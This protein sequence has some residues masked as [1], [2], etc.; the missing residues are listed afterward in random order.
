MVVG[1]PLPVPPGAS[2][3]CRRQCRAV[4]CGGEG[5][6]GWGA[7]CGVSPVR[8]GAGGHPSALGGEA[9]EPRGP[10]V[11]PQLPVRGGAQGPWPPG[12]VG[13]CRGE[14]HYVDPHNGGDLLCSQEGVYP[15]P[16][17]GRREGG[18]GDGCCPIEVGGADPQDPF[19]VPAGRD[20]EEERGV[21]GRS[22]QRTCPLW[23][24]LL[25]LER[26]GGRSGLAQP[27][28][29]CVAGRRAGHQ[30]GSLGNASHTMAYGGVGL[31]PSYTGLVGLGRAGASSAPS[32]NTVISPSSRSSSGGCR[33][34]SAGS[35]S[36]TPPGY[37]AHA[38]FRYGAVS[39]GQRVLRACSRAGAGGHGRPRSRQPQG[40]PH[41]QG[42]ARPVRLAATPSS[43]RSGL[44]PG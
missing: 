11:A 43:A 25:V 32:T 35:S 34:W 39:P 9:G 13:W 3:S 29:A 41:G 14:P 20:D 1:A 6:R 26:G 16:R 42:P 44:P 23:W 19:R 30:V 12:V 36:D 17:R 37:V 18:A 24:A 31:V 28:G 38:W 21:P 4:L 10:R 7:G 5:R 33:R 2:V 15:V 40:V 27:R 22:C 8:A